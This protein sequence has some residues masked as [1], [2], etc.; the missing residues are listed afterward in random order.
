MYIY[1]HIYVCIYIYIYIYICICIYKYICMYVCIHIYVC[2]YIHMYTYTYIYIYIHIYIRTSTGPVFELPAF[3]KLTNTD[4]FAA[5]FVVTGDMT[6]VVR[7]VLGAIVWNSHLPRG[8][9]LAVDNALSAHQHSRRHRA[10][11][12]FVRSRVQRVHQ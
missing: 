3:L 6:P 10:P 11:A 2:I 4:P 9:R 12:A 5:W 1:V 7:S 8:A